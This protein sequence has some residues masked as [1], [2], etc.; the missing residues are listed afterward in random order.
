MGPKRKRLEERFWAKVIK[1]SKC[2]LW[3]GSLR[4]G[5]GQLSETYRTQKYNKNWAAHRLSWTFHFGP[6][7]KGL[8]V[9]H[10]CDN[11]ACVNPSH[12]FI[13]TQ[14]ENLSDM[15]AKGRSTY[16]DRN[17]N[18]RLNTRQVITIRCLRKMGIL[19]NYLSTRF[20]VSKTHVYRICKNL[21]WKCI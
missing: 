2:W 13:G 1:T 11:R 7:P 10:Q 8:F 6:I 17:S 15:V 21:N 4:S 5:Y 20:G 19:P 3:N 16:G 18:A 14:Q 9:C 12:L